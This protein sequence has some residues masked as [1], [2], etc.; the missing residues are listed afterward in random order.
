MA[1]IYMCIINDID[2]EVLFPVPFLP[3]AL[4]IQFHTGDFSKYT[5]PGYILTELIGKVSGSFSKKQFLLMKGK[6]R[7]SNRRKH[8]QN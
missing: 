4:G 2:F 3:G 7:K 6:R 1:G 5:W 8:P